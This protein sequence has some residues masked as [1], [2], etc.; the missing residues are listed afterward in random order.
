MPISV[1]GNEPD[2]TIFFMTYE[3]RWDWEEH[4]QAVKKARE[5]GD[6]VEHRV[7]IIVDALR[8]ENPPLGPALSNITSGIR[9]QRSPNLG[10]LVLVTQNPF[11]R[12][13][14]TIAPKVYP[15]MAD[16]LVLAKT[17]EEAHT[18]IAEAKKDG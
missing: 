1:H 9:L 8:S 14:M 15:G 4:F 6:G 5:F 11:V 7:D 13:L 10:I 12:A 2:H 3:G 18:L 17:V 16:T